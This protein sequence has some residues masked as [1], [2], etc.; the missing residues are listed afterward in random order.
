MFQPARP[1]GQVIESGE[2]PCHFEG[3]V[4]R[5]VDGACQTQAVGDGGESGQHRERCRGARRRLGRGCGRDAHAARPLRE[6][7]V[8]QATLGGSG[9]YGRRSRI[10]SGCQTR[11]RP[12]R[13]VVDTREMGGQVNRL[14]VL[15]FA[16]RCHSPHLFAISSCERNRSAWRCVTEVTT[17]SS[18]A[19]TRCRVSSLSATSSGSPTNCVAVRSLHKLGL[20]VGQRLDGVRVRVRDSHRRPRGSNKPSGRSSMRAAGGGGVVGHHDV[21]A[22]TTTYGFASAADGWNAAR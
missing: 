14:A 21:V 19:V 13:G 16:P 11:R 1:S 6:E 3:F 2:L 20:L 22:Y 7:E 5:R 4:E 12:H 15:P 10:R 17:N 18:A 9:P 8:E